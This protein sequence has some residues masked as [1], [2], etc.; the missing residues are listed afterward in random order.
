MPRCRTAACRV[1]ENPFFNISNKSEIK[2]INACLALIFFVPLQCQMIK[3][4]T[5][6]IK[7]KNCEN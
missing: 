2:Q 5:A 6:V 1:L 7:C 4:V 3:V